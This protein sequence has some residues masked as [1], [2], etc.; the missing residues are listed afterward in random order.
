[1]T[2]FSDTHWSAIEAA[3]G[4]DASA[5]EA[6]VAKYRPA[7]VRFVERRG[8]QR[9]AEDLAQEVLVRLILQG[10]LARVSPTKGRFRS[11]V[12]AVTR[13]VIGNH[14]EYLNAAKR[15][16]GKVLSLPD[17]EI[18]AEQP[19][20]EFDRAWVKNLI[21]QAMAR[22]E[23]LHPR[24]HKAI[25]RFAL[26]GVPQAE[27]ADEL[28]ASRQDVKNYVRRGRARLAELVTEEIRSYCASAD[29]VE[30]ELAAL[31]RYLPS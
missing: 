12:L 30:E 19:D 5:L 11:L 3:Q 16:G 18:E 20:D 13:H 29:E 21:R 23:T 17:V 25:Q 15:G 24:Y 9:D 10:A 4:G 1:M 7:V 8:F 2:E 22:L 27:V 28:G 31:R 6:I 26:D 14:L